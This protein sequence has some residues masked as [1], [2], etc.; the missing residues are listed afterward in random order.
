MSS[1]KVC[2][3]LCGITITHDSAGCEFGKLALCRRCLQRGH[4]AADC[5]MEH[6]QH[7]RPTYFEELIAPDLRLSLGITTQTPIHYTKPRGEPIA[8]ITR[9]EIPESASYDDLGRIIK[10][11]KIKIKRTGKD[12]EEDRWNA[13]K[14][15][16]T[17]NGKRL[18]VTAKVP[19]VCAAAGAA[20]KKATMLP[21]L[22][23]T[24]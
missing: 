14:D 18:V 11:N 16:T 22:I 4:F 6:P 5:T 9:F 10:E 7:E 20:S 1:C 12:S 8:D 13:I 2:K 21:T 19:K 24:C 23:V 15:W 3:K 17:A